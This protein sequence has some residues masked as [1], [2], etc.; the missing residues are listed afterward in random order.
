[1]P[2][3]RLIMDPPALG[4]WNMAVDE[5]LLES[6]AAGGPATLRFYRW[7]EPT[8]SLGYFQPYADRERH[9]PSRGLTVVR[10]ST[11]GGALVH[12]HELTYSLALPAE[13][14]HT[15]DATALTC[16]VHKT[17]IN[18]VN[19]LVLDAKELITC[20]EAITGDRQDE[21]FLCFQRRS[22]GDLLAADPEGTNQAHHKLCG[23]AQRRRRGALLQHGG[24]LL[25]RS[26]GA[27]ELLG[28]DDLGHFPPEWLEKN[29]PQLIDVWSRNLR[30]SLNLDFELSVLTETETSVAKQ[31]AQER[32]SCRSWIKRR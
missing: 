17:F 24:V 3:C 25:A 20:P 5:A 7:S 13:N 32:F 2:P 14:P 18:T 19:K 31:L 15:L 23:S 29:G 28:L 16:L 9:E 8:L 26:K 4:A 27:P 21:P 12:D 11:G 6:V 22:P 10:R 30:E 1:M